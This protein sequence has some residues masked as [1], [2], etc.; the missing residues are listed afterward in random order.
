MNFSWLPGAV[1]ANNILTKSSEPFIA[2]ETNK[3]EN[4]PIVLVDKEVAVAK[5]AGKFRH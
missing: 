5:E 2:A 4:V 1:F 3:K